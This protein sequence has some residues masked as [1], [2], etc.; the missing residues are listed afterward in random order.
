MFWLHGESQHGL[1]LIHNHHHI[2]LKRYIPEYYLLIV[3]IRHGARTS[4]HSLPGIRPP[5]VSC[6][7]EDPYRNVSR[8][9]NNIKETWIRK[10][11]KFGRI[12]SFVKLRCCLYFHP[13]Y[14][15]VIMCCCIPNGVRSDPL[16]FLLLG[17]SCQLSNPNFGFFLIHVSLIL[18]RI[19]DTFL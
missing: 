17:Y 8:I 2:H 15:P 3:M 11:P 10:N 19:R 13:R 4:M 5:L 1:I 14:L 6:Q 18:L 7:I 16:Q 12:W 9:L